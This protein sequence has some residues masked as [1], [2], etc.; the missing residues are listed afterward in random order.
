L[1]ALKLDLKDDRRLPSQ[2]NWILLKIENK[3]LMSHKI[4]ILSESQFKKSI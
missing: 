2:T 4:A 3:N 1:E